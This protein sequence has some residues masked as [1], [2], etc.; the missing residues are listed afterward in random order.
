MPRPE[1]G[2]PFVNTYNQDLIYELPG[3]GVEAGIDLETSARPE[4]VTIG[5]IEYDTASVLKELDPISWNIDHSERI[6]SKVSDSK[7][8]EFDD[9]SNH[10]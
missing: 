4:T 5:W 1:R 6:E 8:I 9:G 7:L 10:Y 3:F 2:L